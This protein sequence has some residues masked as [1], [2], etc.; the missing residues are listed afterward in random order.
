[1]KEFE[2]QP[3]ST[4]GFRSHEAPVDDG[5]AVAVAAAASTV[6]AVGVA[7]AVRTFVHVVGGGAA[8]EAGRSQQQVQRRHSRS[9]DCAADGAAGR[10]SQSPR[11]SATDSD[12]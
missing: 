3:S 7:R 4:S 11:C 5:G 12:Y 6:R 10:A 9:K 1:M 2:T 8:V